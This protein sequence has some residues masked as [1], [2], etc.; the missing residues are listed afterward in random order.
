MPNHVISKEGAGSALVLVPNVLGG[1][2]VYTN[3]NTGDTTHRAK[4]IVQ[5]LHN[6]GIPAGALAYDRIERNHL[7]KRTFLMGLPAAYGP[8]EY[9]A[10]CAQQASSLQKE[11]DEIDPGKVIGFGASA[12][13]QHYLNML[14]TQ[15]IEAP[16]FAVLFD[17]PSV[18]NRSTFG[19][20]GNW[21]VH[22]VAS[23]RRPNE[24]HNHHGMT[25]DEGGTAPVSVLEDM[26]TFRGIWTGEYAKEAL[27]AL[28]RGAIAKSTGEG[29]TT[30][31]TIPALTFTQSHAEAQ[32]LCLN[33]N[34]ET[35]T[36]VHFRAR[37]AP[38]MYHS[39]TDD[40]EVCANLVLNALGYVSDKEALSYPPV[41]GE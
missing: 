35:N 26:A 36:G 39:A 10:L 40:P 2:A 12:G 4:G 21:A 17:P 13:A 30:A 6:Q 14:Q 1:G 8:N 27:L 38:G 5:G 7:N 33:L 20:L 11:I 31:L 18:H 24:A 16:D 41:S 15:K 9:V 37:V 34:N 28:A 29:T 22:Q 19:L 25:S 32:N 3:G 23:M